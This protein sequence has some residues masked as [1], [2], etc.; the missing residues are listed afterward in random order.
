M[1]VSQVCVGC[2]QCSVFCPN[3]AI[4][5]FGR[6]SV[7]ENC[8]GCETCVDYCPLGALSGDK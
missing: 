8:V 7:D 5:V 1:N 3:D 6:A 2:G 4:S